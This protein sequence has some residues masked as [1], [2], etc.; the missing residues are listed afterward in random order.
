M[1][2][3][4]QTN[5]KHLNEIILTYLST[6]RAKKFISR[7]GILITYLLFYVD[8]VISVFL[9][10]SS[11]TFMSL[12]SRIYWTVV[13]G[14]IFLVPLY[15]S[16]ISKQYYPFYLKRRSRKRH[17]SPDKPINW[18]KQGKIFFR[19]SDFTGTI[20][21]FLLAR[22]M[23]FVIAN[24]YSLSYFTIIILGYYFIIILLAIVLYTPRERG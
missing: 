15:F 2:N 17:L 9:W 10:V 13:W 23:D 24:Q 1:L 6:M 4:F 12:I 8:F 3:V 16:R 18:R 21:I 20:F 5:K 22:I 19:M 14:F 7:Y 11:P